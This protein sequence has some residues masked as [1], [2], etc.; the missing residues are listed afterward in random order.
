MGGHSAWKKRAAAGG[1]SK[2]CAGGAIL[3]HHPRLGRKGKD[4]ALNR[5]GNI[6]GRPNPKNKRTRVRTPSQAEEQRD[7]NHGQLEQL[8]SSGSIRTYPII[9]FLAI[10]FLYGLVAKRYWL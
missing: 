3:R 10:A 9:A 6:G 1:L 2:D 5:L 7:L 8:L 4:L